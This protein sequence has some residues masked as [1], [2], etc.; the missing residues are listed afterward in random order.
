MFLIASL[1]SWK[2]KKTRSAF[3]SAIASNRKRQ[4][5]PSLRLA[6][7]VAA[8]QKKEVDDGK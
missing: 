3:Y 7:G 2:A 4:R 5:Q 1:P 8:H 6:L